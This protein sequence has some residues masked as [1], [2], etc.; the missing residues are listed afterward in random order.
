MNCA[1]GRWMEPRILSRQDQL[2]TSTAIASSGKLDGDDLL[3]H[4]KLRLH[5]DE[6]ADLEAEQLRAVAR[7][8]PTSKE[9]RRLAYKTY[10]ARR[11]RNRIVEEKIFGEPAWDM[12]LALYCLPSRGEMLT[13]TGLSYAADVPLATGLRWQKTLTAYGLIERSPPDADRRLV[14]IGLTKVGRELMGRL[15]T[16]LYHCEPRSVLHEI[17]TGQVSND[18]TK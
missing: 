10:N 14:F 3:L 11:L 17:T 13:V 12:L 16:R 2:N 18:S 5:L 6:I 1:C 8:Q 4:L 15:M 7:R 9:L